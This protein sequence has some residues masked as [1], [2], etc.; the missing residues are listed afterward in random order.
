MAFPNKSQLNWTIHGIELIQ[1]AQEIIK[2]LN[3]TPLTDKW[4]EEAE[5]WQAS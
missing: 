2:D 1:R 4:L 3:P 5:E